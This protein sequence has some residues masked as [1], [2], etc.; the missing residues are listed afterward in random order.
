MNTKHIPIKNFLLILPMRSIARYLGFILFVSSTSLYALS[1][2]ITTP[3]WETT[4]GT[5][6]LYFDNIFSSELLCDGA[7]MVVW[8]FNNIGQPICVTPV[9]TGL[10]VT[11]QT[12]GDT[13]RFDGSSW[14]RNNLLYNDGTA[15]GIADQT[16]SYLLDVGGTANFLGIRF[17]TWASSWYV[18]TS[19]ASGLASWSNA[20]NISLSWV[21]WGSQYVVPK[22]GLWWT[23]LI[24]SSIYDDG[25]TVGINTLVPSASYKLDVV[26]GDARLNGIRF[27]V[28]WGNIASNVAIGLN[29]FGANVTSPNNVI[30]G[31]LAGTTLTAG[32]GG[33]ILIWNS[34]N[35]S[36]ATSSN[37]LNIGNWIYGNNG[38]IGLGTGAG[39]TTRLLVDGQIQITGGSPAAGRYLQ[40]D[41]NGIGIWTWVTASSVTATGIVWGTEY[42]LTK[43]W[44]GGNGI[45]A[46]VLYESGGMLGLNTMNPSVEFDVNGT[47]RVRSWWYSL[48][49]AHFRFIMVLPLGR[50]LVCQSIHG[51]LSVMRVRPLAHTFSV[52]RM[53]RT[54]YS[55]QTMSNTCGFWRLGMSASVRHLLGKNSPFRVEIFNTLTARNE[56]VDI[57]CLMQM[58]LPLG[59]DM[60]SQRASI[61][62]APSQVLRSTSVAAHGMSEPGIYNAWGNIGIGTITPGSALEVAGQVKITGEVLQVWGNSSFLM[63]LVL[64][65]GKALQQH[66]QVRIGHFQEIPLGP[67]TLSDPWMRKILWLKS[68]NVQIGRFYAGWGVSLWTGNTNEHYSQY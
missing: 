50:R 29:A 41:A 49:R 1:Y 3:A 39:I 64:R 31:N 67:M 42:Y 34:V 32:A 37:E 53:L 2:P 44:A 55:R 45:Y 17:P 6:R 21:T 51:T 13:L 61:S 4:G 19:D 28:G 10:Y 43:F 18:L 9:S 59:R 35:T 65:A 11:G 36:L 47:I 15:I 62:L 20:P 40:S 54:S 60:S 30:I 26:W 7:N 12:I 63:Q 58:V 56:M 33:N 24:L 38:N 46:S 22:F 48:I 5:Y 68:N 23:G 25:V 14:V 57:L 66:S 8:G 16:P 52:L 27:G